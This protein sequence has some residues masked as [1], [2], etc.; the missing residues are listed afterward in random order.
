MEKIIILMVAV[1]IS[2]VGCNV[3]ESTSNVD[4]KIEQTENVQTINIKEYSGIWLDADQNEYGAS[5]YLVPLD[6][7]TAVISNFSYYR[8][9]G[10]SDVNAVFDNSETAV[11]NSNGIKGSIILSNGDTAKII[12]T[13]D[14]YDSTFVGE[15][16]LKLIEKVENVISREEYDK[17][18]DKIIKSNYKEISEKHFDIVNESERILTLNL[19]SFILDNES[20]TYLT[21][22]QKYI[23]IDKVNQKVILSVEDF[24]NNEETRLTKLKNYLEDETNKALEN[25]TDEEKNTFNNNGLLIY[26]IDDENKVLRIQTMSPIEANKAIREI[27]IDVPYSV[28]E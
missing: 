22:T 24:L 8:T 25:Y 27:W 15:Y 5:M 18:I 28:F 13:E 3:K 11:F 7:K 23:Y 26:Q 19:K 4:G 1:L 12:I 14:N 6:E 2:L 20:Y 16:N 10:M 9:F 21:G 17:A